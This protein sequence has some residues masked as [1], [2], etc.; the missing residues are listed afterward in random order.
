MT[1]YDPF[2]EFRRMQREMNRAFERFFGSPTE[3]RLLTG[4]QGSENMLGFREP[5][6]DI[7]QTDSE[8]KIA[9]E[10]PGV[11]K[12]DIELE[13]KDNMLCVKAQRSHEIKEDKKGYF[14]LERR[15]QGFHR[16]I[17][18][19]TP[20]KAGEASAEYK[21]GVLQVSVPKL[22]VLERK[23]KIQIK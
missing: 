14:R 7:K 17:P 9:L 13:V 1:I 20:V 2:E 16:V 21:N 6:A 18:L 15:Y 19:P 4:N 23:N 11:N 8:V 12:E 5:L 10:L 22:K 3:R